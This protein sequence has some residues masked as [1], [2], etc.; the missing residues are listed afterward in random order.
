MTFGFDRI[1]YPRSE[2]SVS[3]LSRSSETLPLGT[4]SYASYLQ[5]LMARNSRRSHLFASILSKSLMTSAFR[6]SRVPSL[7]IM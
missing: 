4:A 7:T 6:S 1:S 3:D 5:G 2:S